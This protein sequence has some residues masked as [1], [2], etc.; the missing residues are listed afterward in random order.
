MPRSLE[1]TVEISG[2]LVSAYQVFVEM[3]QRAFF[4]FFVRAHVLNFETF[5]FEV[6]CFKFFRDCVVLSLWGRI[7]CMHRHGILS[8]QEV[9]FQAY[10]FGGNLV[11]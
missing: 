5:T 10:E 3:S 8:C 9:N 6:G 7:K 1:G 2:T 11:L 4:F